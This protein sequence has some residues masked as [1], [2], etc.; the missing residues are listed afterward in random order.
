MILKPK[1]L[2]YWGFNV[3]APILCWIL[4]RRFNKLVINSIDLKPNC[5]Y[6]LL[7][8]HIGFWDGFWGAYLC[9][10]LM[11]K[12]V[13]LRAFFAMSLKKQLEKNQWL[14]Y[15]GCFS[16][17]PFGKSRE[18]S[19]DFAAKILNKPGNILLFYPQGNLESNYVRQIEL[20]EGI[21]EILAKT[22]ENCQII[23]TSNLIEYFESLKA[24][25]YFHML[26]C[27]TNVNFNIDEL[28]QK[29]N[30]HHQ[31]SI[32]KQFRFTTEVETKRA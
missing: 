30:D 21:A 11:D 22:N 23:W 4:K 9:Y 28:S 17:S 1:K 12:R 31:K 24:S 29:I 19:I 10:K 13:P 16:V 5:S 18:E 3:P 8:N 2:P 7:S 32:Q 26:D 14:R 15:F 6:L 27:G 25:V 20:R